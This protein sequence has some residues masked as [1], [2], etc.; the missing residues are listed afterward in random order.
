MLFQNIEFDIYSKEPIC[1]IEMPMI[2]VK[3]IFLDEQ[4]VVICVDGILDCESVPILKDVFER[5]RKRKKRV[6]LNLKGLVHLTR[7]GKKFLQEMQDNGVY[8]EPNEE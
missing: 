6:L 5:N 1:F 8:I 2:Y 7:E 4:L 3:E